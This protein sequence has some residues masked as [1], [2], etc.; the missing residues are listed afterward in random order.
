MPRRAPQHRPPATPRS[1]GGFSLVE[2]LVVVAVL[3]IAASI[4]VPQ[5]RGQ[6]TTQLR[7]A[8]RLLAA[9]LDAAKADALTHPDDP[10]VVVFDLADHTYHLA[11]VSDP[12]TP[13]TNPFD[14]Q[15][16]RVVFGQ[17]RA[18][19]LNDV[20]LH[21][22]DLDGDD[23]LGFGIYGQ[24]DQTDPAVI[25]LAAGEHTLDLTLDPATGEAT[26]GELQ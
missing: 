10:S 21:A 15:P 3:G 8:A 12:D 13:V 4:A 16:Y 24:L 11:R 9:D 23:R 18:A 14:Q 19:A 26:I 17:G 25:T 5:F 22:T 1:R 6:H 20:T 2:L 7:S